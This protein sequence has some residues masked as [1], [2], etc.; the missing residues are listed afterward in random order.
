MHFTGLSLFAYIGCYVAQI[1][2]AGQSDHIAGELKRA[3]ST[4]AVI[5]TCG[6]AIEVLSGLLGLLGQG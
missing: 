4:W 3:L 6:F 2:G 5:L 1:D